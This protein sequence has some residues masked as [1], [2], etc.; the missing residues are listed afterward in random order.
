M[1][2]ER[3]T[4][5][6]GYRLHM[7]DSNKFKT[8]QIVL[9]FR[10]SLNRETITKRA[11]L[12]FVLQQGT[13][14]YPSQAAFRQ[15]LDYL[16]GAGLTIDGAKKGNQH[17]LTFRMEIANQA[18]LTEDFNIF[19]E[20]IQFLHDVVYKPKTT[21]NGFDATYVAREKQTLSQKISSIVDNKM[22]YANMRLID[23]MC[24]EEAYRLHVHGYKTDLDKINEKNLYHYYQQLITE[25]PMDIYVLGDFSA[26]D[27]EAHI[28]NVFNHE[29]KVSHQ[30]VAENEHDKAAVKEIIEQQNI[31]QAKLHLGYRTNITYVDSLYP[32]L[33][34]FNG[35]FGGFPSSKLFLNVREKNSLAYYAA[36]RFESHK[37]LLFVFSGIDPKDYQKARQ[38]ILDQ[39]EAMQQGD[40]TDAEVEEAKKQVINQWKE[41]M[42][43]PNGCIELLYHQV[44]ANSDQSPL[45][46]LSRIEEVTKEDLLQVSKRLYLDT[47]YF[48]TTEEGVHH[49]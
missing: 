2:S 48:L 11:L 24:V 39:M 31:Q 22:S 15:A 1:I 21:E 18:Y 46:I 3:T 35:V 44:L 33:Q 20:A 37:G 5:Q 17:I 42:D 47:I 41:T 13:M 12:P 7:I 8:I 45:D 27:V 23:E 28:S 4:D 6:H 43:N 19:Q 38:I 10:A 26:I 29:R 32:A 30:Q 34:V 16:Y 36:S 14:K 9:K 25:N 49:G 40:F